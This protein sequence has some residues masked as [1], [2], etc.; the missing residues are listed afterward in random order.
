MTSP[1][2]G[3]IGGCG[4]AGGRGRA[5][6]CGGADQP[7]PPW[8]PG[9]AGKLWASGGRGAVAIPGGRDWNG[10]LIGGGPGRG[11]EGAP[12]D[13]SAADW[14]ATAASNSICFNRSFFLIPAPPSGRESQLLT[15]RIV[16]SVSETSFC[17]RRISAL[18]V[19]NLI[20]SVTMDEAQ[21]NCHGLL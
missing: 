17:R 10:A 3:R 18:R 6:S 15:E 19:R 1:T 4:R 11:P 2:D 7:V 20:V 13:C 16:P 8:E 21:W 5:D 14:A 12:E 9:A